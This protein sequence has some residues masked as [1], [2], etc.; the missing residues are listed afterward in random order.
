MS[1]LFIADIH[2]GNEHPDISQR[3]SEF[4]LQATPG[5]EALYIL[6]DLFEVWIGDDAVQAEQQATLNTLRQLT[7][8]GLPVYVMHGNRDFLLGKQ[9]E[10]TTGCQ[11]II[12]PIVIDL[13]G[14]PTLLMHGDTLCTDDISYQQFRHQVRDKAWQ[15]AFLAHSVEERAAYANKVREES[16]RKGME[17]SASIMDVNEQAVM[18]MMKQ[19]NVKRLIHGHTHRPDVHELQIDGEQARRIVL[20]DWYTQDSWLVC[21][22]EGCDLK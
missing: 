22:D 19:H 15:K 3:F 21:S 1:T 13:Y 10:V 2:L 9:F 8:N 7:D 18:D 6:G 5:A 16:R 12:D 14:T 4:L 17:N 20:G 11:L